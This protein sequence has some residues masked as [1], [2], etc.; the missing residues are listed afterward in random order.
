MTV[1]SSVRAWIAG[2]VLTDSNMRTFL[3]DPIED[4]AGR[5]GSIEF[6]DD[7]DPND[8]TAYILPETSS[9]PNT[10]LAKNDDEQPIYFDSGG[11]AREVF[12][13]HNIWLPSAEVGDIPRVIATEV[14]HKDSG[15]TRTLRRLTR[16]A[17]PSGD[18]SWFLNNTSAGALAWT[19]N[20]GPQ[21]AV[22]E[23]GRWSSSN[24]VNASFTAFLNHAMDPDRN[25][26][27]NSVPDRMAKVD[28]KKTLLIGIGG[29]SKN[30]SETITLP[31]IGQYLVMVP[32][33][34]AISA[35][36][37]DGSVI[38]F[39]LEDSPRAIQIDLTNPDALDV[40]F[41]ANSITWFGIFATF[42]ADPVIDSPSW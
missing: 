23:V 9:G 14:S 22:V 2:E 12:D 6:E 15:D 20:V 8:G 5:N 19:Q 35:S 3:N 38:D 4:L 10:S 17:R 32:G 29:S 41:I 21:R 24:N 37:T 26:T 34:N 18:G 39:E 42:V 7:L 36:T 40:T 1:I 30:F 31:Y 27:F 13:A 11:T 25:P 33:N 16:L 28:A